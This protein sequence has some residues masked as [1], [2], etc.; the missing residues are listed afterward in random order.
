MKR[1]LLI[2]LILAVI[3]MLMPYHCKLTAE[4]VTK[5]VLVTWTTPFD[6]VSLAGYEMRYF[7]GVLDSTTWNQAVTINP[8]SL[9]VP[10]LPGS[11]DSVRLNLILKVGWPY[12]LGMMSF[13]STGNYSGIS[14]IAQF[15]IIDSLPPSR[16]TDLAVTVE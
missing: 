10:G 12:Q 6:N 8:D 11:P 1:F 7:D 15:I 9:P 4:D 2:N 14:N 5:T 16:V 13:D 3:I